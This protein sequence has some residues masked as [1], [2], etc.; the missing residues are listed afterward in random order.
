MY[1]AKVL[2]V[3]IASP[4]DVNDERQILREV[5]YSWNFT[6]SIKSE[7][8]VLPLG[9]ETHASPE[10]G[11]TP[12]DLINVRLLERC[13]ILVGVFG[14]RIGTATTSEVS[15]TVEEIKRHS[16]AGK[17]ALVYFSS[18][19][20]DRAKFDTEQYGKLQ[21]FKSWCQS[22]G[23]FW[24]FSSLADLRE[25]F[26][27]H[28]RI[29]LT[30]NE[31]VRGLIDRYGTI[32]SLSE[33]EKKQA[34]IPAEAAYLLYQAAQTDGVLLLAS[35]L[36]GAR[37]QAGKFARDLKSSGRE[38]AKWRDGIKKLEDY[39]LIEE[40]SFGSGM[41]FITSIGY[42]V[43]DENRDDIER[44]VEEFRIDD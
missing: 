30:E 35:H 19:P 24:E 34:S 29:C 28:F 20:I 39:G 9:W 14:S 6:D 38:N 2:P 17:P 23:M 1:N 42:E 40:R 8:V 32:Q 12:Q 11:A 44:I 37:L 5:V 3:M 25:K 31:Y 36:G 26:E 7:L 4:S 27:R 10:M 15:G 21:E 33:G 43:L 13:D 22:S 41:Y 16:S 18:G